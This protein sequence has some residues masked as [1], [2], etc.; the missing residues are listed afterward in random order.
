[1]KILLISIVGLVVFVMSVHQTGA[2]LPDNKKVL[3]ELDAEYQLAVQKNDAETMNRILHEDFALVLGDGRSVGR[4]HLLKLARDKT[5][6]W[7][8]QESSDRTVRVWGDTAVVTALLH[9]KGVR[10][11]KTIEQKL[12]FS[13]TY[14][15]TAKGWRYVFGQ[16][17]LP[18]PE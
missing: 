7:E 18:L 5:I 2:L 9:E 17:S 11:G 16:A 3:A 4:E 13:D 14:V 6:V 15:R 1:M 10:G 8:K 12:W